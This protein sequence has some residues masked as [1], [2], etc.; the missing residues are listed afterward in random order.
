MGHEDS[1]M[2]LSRATFTRSAL[3]ATAA[4]A[5]G[6]PAGA[7]TPKNLRVIYFPSADILPWY[8]ALCKGFFAAHGVQVTMTPTPGSVYQFQ[9]MSAGDFDIALTAIDNAIAYDEG[10][11]QAP[12]PK[13]ADFIAFMGGDN[14]TLSDLRGKPI[15][16]DALTTG[17]AF[18]LRKML[19]A[20]GLHD[21]DYTLVPAGGTLQRFQRITTTPDFAA[22]LL[23]VPFDI[24]VI[25][26]RASI[27]YSSMAAS[28]AKRRLMMPV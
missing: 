28:I 16:V 8:I 18:V 12:L 6:L 10:Q 4:A 19:E 5:S 14:A 26:P 24:Q 21:G 7:Q 2:N 15:A 25:L 11:G 17:F 3:A 13:P 1:E 9:H 23:T 22:T 20:N 27:R